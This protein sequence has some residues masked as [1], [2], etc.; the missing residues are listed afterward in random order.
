M[1]LLETLGPIDRTTGIP[2]SDNNLMVDTKKWVREFFPHNP[3]FFSDSDPYYTLVDDDEHV[4]NIY[5]NIEKKEK[6][7]GWKLWD[8]TKVFFKVVWYD[9]NWMFPQLITTDPELHIWMINIW[10]VKK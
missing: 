3:V 6:K 5:Q 1:C 8:L 10:F 2:G 7:K 4:T 9:Q